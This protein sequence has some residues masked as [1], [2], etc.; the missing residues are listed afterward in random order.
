MPCTPLF[1]EQ[2]I[3]PDLDLGKMSAR[4][5][6]KLQ[7]NDASSKEWFPALNHGV[8]PV[9]QFFKDEHAKLTPPETAEATKLTLEIKHFLQLI[10]HHKMASES[11]IQVF[12]AQSALEKTYS[13]CCTTL[14]R[15]LG[16]TI[17]NFT[18]LLGDIV[19]NSLL[20]NTAA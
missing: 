1:A 16:F 5:L 12:L 7:A 4:E 14:H 17:K 10:R 15:K 11:T 6:R 3:S 13:S 9:P 20:P 19:A 8:M 2:R 18:V